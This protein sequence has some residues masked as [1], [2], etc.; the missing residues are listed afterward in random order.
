M[1]DN[2]K[3]GLPDRHLI[4]AK[5]SQHLTEGQHDEVLEAVAELAAVYLDVVPI[6]RRWCI[7]YPDKLAMRFRE[8]IES[9]M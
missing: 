3:S 1:P 7:A 8:L 6:E 2:S 4:L 5:H 9:V